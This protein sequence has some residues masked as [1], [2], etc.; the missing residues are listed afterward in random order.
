M[1]IVMPMPM[2]M[3]MPNVKKETLPTHLEVLV[4]GIS[5]GAVVGAQHVEHLHR[6][7][8]NMNRCGPKER[9]ECS[10]S[11]PSNA[12]MHKCTNVKCSNAQVLKCTNAQMH[13]YQMLK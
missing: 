7:K 6:N 1:G 5:A 2:P 10:Y 4:F 12:Q 8:Q 9:I 13:Q 11:Q 3:P